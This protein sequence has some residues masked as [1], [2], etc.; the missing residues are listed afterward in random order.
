LASTLPV[1]YA[2]QLASQRPIEH[3]PTIVCFTN[4]R[5][6][7]SYPQLGHPFAQARPYLFSNTLPPSVV[8]ATIK[9]FDLI[10]NDTTLID[11][12]AGKMSLFRFYGEQLD[13]HC[14][15][16]CHCSAAAQVCV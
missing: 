2:A 6:S 3:P 4:R 10:E 16:R 14:G 11:K 12:L 8:G 15:L 1:N 5:I 9:V 7:L 13:V